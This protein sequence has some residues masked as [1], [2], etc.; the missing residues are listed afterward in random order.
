MTVAPGSNSWATWRQVRGIALLINASPLIRERPRLCRPVQYSAPSSPAEYIHRIGRTARIG[1]HGSSL[2]IL[3]P[4]EAEYV[5]S[6]AA[7]K[8]K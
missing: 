7:H 6:L 4:S 8:I 2:L 1:C 5:N 3:A